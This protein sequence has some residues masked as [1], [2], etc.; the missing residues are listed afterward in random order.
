[1]KSGL[2]LFFNLGNKFVEE[3]CWSI[4]SYVRSSIIWWHGI[5]TSTNLRPVELTGPS[6]R[7]LK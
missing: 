4:K 7:P 6:H 3:E 2:K 5:L 1:M